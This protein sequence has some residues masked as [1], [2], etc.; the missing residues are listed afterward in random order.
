MIGKEVINTEVETQLNVS[1][2]TTGLYLAKVTEDGKT[3][4]KRL[5]I[6]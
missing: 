6:N 1:S 3:S 5:A 2:L 4:T